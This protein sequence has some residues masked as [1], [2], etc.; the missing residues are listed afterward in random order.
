MD[1]K[2]SVL[3]FPFHLPKEPF[4]ELLWW[5]KMN[6][7][8]EAGHEIESELTIDLRDKQTRHMMKF[9]DVLSTLNPTVSIV[10]NPPELI[11]RQEYDN[12]F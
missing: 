3:H 5:F 6:R 10:K 2:M 7:C 12:R 8:F 1:R 11:H 4:Q 9:N